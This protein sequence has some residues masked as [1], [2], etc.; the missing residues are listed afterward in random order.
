MRY[1][2]DSFLNP[3]SIRLEKSF[4]KLD[5]LRRINGGYLA[6]P[7]PGKPD[8]IG[9]YNVFWLRDIMYATYANDK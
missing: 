9:K 1:S 7:N 2:E 3:K 5:S 8:G 6:S 4:Q